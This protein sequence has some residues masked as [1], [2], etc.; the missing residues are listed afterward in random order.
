MKL[1]ILSDLHNEFSIFPIPKIERDLLILAGDIFAA[2]S[3]EQ[4]YI[5]NYMPDNTVYIP[6]NHE[7]YGSGIFKTEQY[8][9]E[10]VPN[11]FTQMQVREIRGMRIAGCTLWTDLNKGDPR[12][13]SIA[14]REMNDYWQIAYME[15]AL[16][17]YH[18][19]TLHRQMV[20]WLYSLSNIDVVVT[21]HL[22]SYKS[23][24]KEFLGSPLNGAYASDLED[25]IKFL[26]PKLWVHG[27]THSSQDY[28][29]GSTR[30]VCNPRGYDFDGGKPQNKDFNPELIVE[31]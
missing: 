6:G 14:S 30:I 20:E 21:H 7:Y 11:I 12:T 28:F 1:H 25:L 16:S 15:K 31:V 26:K 5:K 29:I 13:I 24:S 2:K 10:L 8:Y 27:H 23:I 4:I 22:P 9:Q 18:T 19:L 3:R 17:P